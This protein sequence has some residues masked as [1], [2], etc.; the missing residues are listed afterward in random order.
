[1]SGDALIDAAEDAAIWAAMNPRE[2]DMHCFKLSHWAA[3]GHVKCDCPSN[4]I[5][6]RWYRVGV[7]GEKDED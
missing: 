4:K 3:T 2:Y 1:M 6:P 5:V 7:L